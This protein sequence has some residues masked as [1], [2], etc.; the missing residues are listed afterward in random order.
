MISEDDAAWVK[1]AAPVAP[2]DLQEF[3]QDI[4][5]VLRV[6]PRIEFTSLTRMPAGLLH[7]VGHNDS[8]NQSFDITAE[9]AASTDGNGFV[10]RYQTGIKRE[11]R[12]EIAPDAHG[13]VLTITEIYDT[14]G[15]E[16]RARRLTEVDR[17]LVPWAA[18]LRAHLLRKAR[19]GNLPG[20]TWLVE[21][22]WLGMPPRQRRVARMIIWA[23]L[24]EFVVFLAV[25][26]FYTAN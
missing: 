13:A 3:L 17:S 21:R 26:A 9:F 20:Y 12:F 25:L 19:W 5:L 4:E 7:L 1:L 11:T 15:E 10:M 8:N 6:N 22:F 14:P 24:L 16:E 23:T 18:A 2:A